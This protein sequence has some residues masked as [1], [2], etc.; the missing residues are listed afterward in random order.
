VIREAGL[1]LLAGAALSLLALA[2]GGQVRAADVPDLAAALEAQRPVFSWASSDLGAEDLLVVDGRSAAAFSRGHP[3]GALH[4]PFEERDERVHPLPA[5]RQVRAVVVV[6]EAARAAEAR[7]LAQWC[8]REW[9][10]P[11]VATFR[12]GWEAWPR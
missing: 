8:A 6:M 4:V 1:L 7:E 9:A 2:A 5:G 11:V 10:V 3:D 12:G